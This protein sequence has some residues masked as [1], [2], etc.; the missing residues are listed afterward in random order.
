MYEHLKGKKLL[1][2][3]SDSGSINII[4]AA[5]DMGVYTIVVDGISDRSIAPGKLVLHLRF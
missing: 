5:R 1:I 4:D 3:G 2:I